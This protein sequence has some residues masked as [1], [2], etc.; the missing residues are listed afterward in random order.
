MWSWAL[1][2]MQG[3]S[4]TNVATNWWADEKKKSM[5]QKNQRRKAWFLYQEP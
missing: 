2:A 5:S 1:V 3:M 4:Y